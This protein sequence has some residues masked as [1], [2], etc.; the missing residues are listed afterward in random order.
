MK[1]FLRGSVL[2]AIIGLLPC[3]SRGEGLPASFSL[4]R[5]VPGDWWMYIHAVE[6]PERAWIQQQWSGVWDA[7]SRSGIDKDLIGLC[8]SLVDETDRASAEESIQRGR[9]LIAGVRWGDLIGREVMVAERVAAPI[10]DW[11]MMARGREG[12]GESNA[13]GLAAILAQIDSLIDAVELVTEKRNDVEVWRLKLPEEA[14]YSVNLF[15]RGDVIGVTTSESALDQTIQLMLGTAKGPAIVDTARF[16]QALSEVKK[17]EDSVSYLDLKMLFAGLDGVI[18]HAFE[19]KELNEDA[20]AAKKGIGKLLQLADFMDYMI[21]SEE[22]EGR[23]AL[24]H[25]VCK[26]RADRADSPVARAFFRRTPFEQF[27]RYIPATATGFKVSTF[28]DIPLLYATALEFIQQNVPGGADTVKN[29]KDG[30]ASVGF[31]PE[32]DIFSWWSGE[33]ISV[34]MPAAVVTPMGGADSVMMIRV[35]DPKVAAEKLDSAINGLKGLIEKGGKDSPIPVVI[36]PASG[37]PDGFREI[38]FAPM[39]MFVRPVMGVSG[40]FLVVATSTASVNKCMDVAAGKAPSIL[41]NER[42]AAEGI[43]PK[44]PVTAASF[45]DTSRLAQELGGVLMA[46]SFGGRLAVAQIP[47]DG[48]DD[49]ARKAKQALGKAFEILMKLGPVLNKIDFYSSESSVSTVDGLVSRTER[50]VTY[51]HCAATGKSAP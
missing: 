4:G 46:L 1:R 13:K 47:S 33:M 44:G 9:D 10:P 6:N 41:K 42:F 5:Y 51:K 30:M 22:T 3:S 16:K 18:G 43:V 27:D 25:S 48:C 15:R 45:A 20:A 19:G 34:E 28:I 38:M 21:A 7:F 26:L 40:D 11:L 17:P 24:T 36:A 23:Q 50:V 32:R 35:K 37:G 31:D 8:L 14:K 29:M 2:F 39:A 12:S 49:D